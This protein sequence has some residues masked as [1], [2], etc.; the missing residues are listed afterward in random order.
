MTGHYGR[1]QVDRAAT[2]LGAFWVAGREF[3][4]LLL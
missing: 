3:I 2:R 4:R 1:K